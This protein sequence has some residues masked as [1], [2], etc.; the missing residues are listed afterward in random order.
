MQNSGKDCKR[1]RVNKN[2]RKTEMP[3][4]KIAELAVN[5]KD[6]I[7]F[8]IGEPN[9]DTAEHIKKAAIECIVN[10][11][12]N[13]YAPARGVDKLLKAVADYESKKR[14]ITEPE[15]VLITNGGMGALSNIFNSML[16]DSEEVALS[17]PF[18]AP[19]TMI[20]DSLNK[21]Y[22][23]SPFIING[24][25]DEECLIESLN[26]NTKMIL[27][28]SPC[29]PTGEMLSNKTL[30]I[31]AEIAEEKDLI[32]VSD[33]VY[34]RIVF[35]EKFH[36][37]AEI[38]PERT[39]RIN[40]VSKTY[41]MIPYRVGWITGPKQVINELNKSNHAN[42]ASVNTIGQYAAISALNSSQK[43]VE[44]QRKEYEKRLRLIERR[45][46]KLGWSSPKVKGAFYI[47]PETGKD[48][49]DYA[50]RLIEKAGVSTVPGEVF[51]TAGKD[52]LR[53]CFGCVNKDEINEGFDRIEDNE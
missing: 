42:V 8:D 1:M 23:T 20:L 46:N 10:K 15:N 37:I 32:I 2:I 12:R 34:E 30:R 52:C 13:G 16:E 44:E 31:I 18:W 3:I 45:I 5:K 6:C 33:E 24:E 50:K 21:K 19:Y 53:F 28:N 11:N 14:I 47:F 22:N 48:S 41:N 29:N 26:D 39:L 43:H 51:G 36:T 7:R 9:F 4:R 49:W 17:D 35:E 25:L 40:S 38:C 27:L